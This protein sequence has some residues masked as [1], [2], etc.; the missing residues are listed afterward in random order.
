MFGVP[1]QTV[2]PTPGSPLFTNQ[3]LSVQRAAMVLSFFLAFFKSITHFFDAVKRTRTM[4]LPYD[5][6]TNT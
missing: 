5:L 4:N 1:L 3:G 2:F 6:T